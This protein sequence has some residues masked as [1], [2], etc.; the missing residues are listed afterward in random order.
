MMLT[1]PTKLRVPGHPRAVEFGVQTRFAYK[2]A[3][4]SRYPHRALSLAIYKWLFF[5]YPYAVFFCCHVYLSASFFH[6]Y[7]SLFVL[8]PLIVIIVSG[9]EL[10]VAT[11]RPET[12]LA[13]A[14]VAVHPADSRYS[15]FVGKQV[16]QAPTSLI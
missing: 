7:S 3:D 4:D 15:A 13:D 6:L 8:F 10:V 12:M 16:T 11:T 1:G 14:A 9:A 2:L 5:P